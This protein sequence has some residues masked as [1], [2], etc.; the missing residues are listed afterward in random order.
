MAIEN[1]RRT[2]EV[3][4][5]VT[6]SHVA[7]EAP[8]AALARGAGF[9]RYLVLERLGSGGMGVV[10]AAYDPE[11]DRKV[12]IK[13]LRPEAVQD[14]S[15]LRR[16]AQA[17]ARLQHPNV[18]GIHDAG[19]EEGRAFVAMELVDGTTLAHWL[20]DEG[21]SWRDIVDIFV[22][23]G[24]GLVAAHAIGLIHRDFKPANVLVGRD[25]RVRVGDFGLARAV[26]AAGRA[27]EAAE[28][29]AAAATPPALAETITR[30]GSVVGTPTYMSPEQLAGAA[31]DAKS[32]QFS[33]CVALYRALYR[34]R[35]FA[36]DDVASLSAEMTRGRVPTPPKDSRVPSWVRDAVLRGLSIDPERRWPSMESLLHALGR[37]PA[38]VRRRRV[39]AIAGVLVVAALVLGVRAV[40][41]RQSMVCRGAERRLAGVWDDGRKQAVHAAFAATGKS[42]AEGAFA[43][44]ARVLDRYAADWA[45]MH[46][47]ACE[48]T[49]LR[50]S[51][52]EEL[53][54]LRMECLDARLQDVKAQ[55][56]LFSSADAT[57][58]MKA[59]QI[60]ASLPA[61]AQCA[62]VAALRA[63]VRPPADAGT[64]ARVDA[65]RAK[66]AQAK[67]QSR[68]LATKRG[69]EIA[70]P[71]V[72]E[73][74]ALKYRP[75]EAEALVTL[76]TLQQQAGDTKTAK[77]TLEEGLLAARAGR[78]PRDEIYAAAAL[79][80]VSAGQGQFA[81]G[82]QWERRGLASVEAMGG[83]D[84]EPLAT[85]LQR[86]AD[87][88]SAQGKTDEAT[89]RD[90]RL[91]AIREK[92]DG[93]DSFLTSTAHGNLGRELLALNQFGE[94]E[95]E[96]RLAVTGF[97]KQVGPNHAN[98]GWAL[99]SLATVMARTGRTVE[100]EKTL[101]RSVD[102]YEQA[103]GPEHGQLA[104]PIAN[105]AANLIEQGRDEEGL[106]L[107]R[108]SLAIGVKTMGPDHPSVGLA[109]VN[110]G[111]VL[112]KE[113]K[114]SEAQEEF[115]HAL[116][117]LRKS[118]PPD[119]FLI[120]SALT[121]NAL[122][123]IYLHHA[124]RAVPVMQK[125]LT[126]ANQG[127]ADLGHRRFVLAR[128]MWESGG[129]HGAAR[130]LVEEA[131]KGYANR[132]GAAQEELAE[133][134]K[135]LATH[136]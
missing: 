62:D 109:T 121:S 21:R 96:L 135:W 60:A 56:E 25:G 14:Q 91:L 47:D 44:V 119:H 41:Q 126:M 95:K 130:K 133:I 86:A 53:M 102:I 77:Q 45:A 31:T 51:Q 84:R 27:S 88:Y 93:P 58:A 116:A 98:V 129:D 48:A 131:R 28:L 29:A 16:E 85:L 46:T 30:T 104:I 32:D 64:R 81:D 5:T 23:A 54:D 101:R 79:E 6:S 33:F 100:A 18:I 52:S 50:G 128:A 49:R 108:R 115:Q 125:T 15:R 10:Y 127:P 7:P 2:E 120:A 105:L 124:A 74:R 3:A 39:Q 22:H 82:E 57:L 92:D 13:I 75:L 11:L 110:I 68:S 65:V 37:D 17:M 69:L 61:L 38:R 112:L 94:A 80:S 97:E 36:G 90:R 111:N 72:S 76:G 117:I 43:S 87:V 26:D 34:E 71:A 12:A 20:D 4:A 73:A 40:Q 136:R 19:M 59:P 123:D 35:P 1:D 132:D 24:R 89:A 122:A 134:D 9:G 103:F 99:L 70:T 67:A 55:V 78:D 118:L 83:S 107:L 106:K 66:L 114:F 63:P 113:N 8:Q 42:Y